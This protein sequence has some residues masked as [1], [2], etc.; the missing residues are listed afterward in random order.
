MKYFLII[1]ASLLVISC[2][3]KTESNDK[4]SPSKQKE[5]AKEQHEKV[6]K[7]VNYDGLLEVL[8][9][10]DDKLYVVNF[11]ATWCVPCVEELPHFME[12]N[13]AH[14]DNPNYQ[15]IL[16][17]LDRSNQLETGVKSF[18]EKNNIPTDCYLLD[19]VKRMDYW[20]SDIDQNW[21]GSIPIT[22]LYKNGEK[23][24]FKEGQ[25]SKAELEN[26]IT[27]HI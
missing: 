27:K 5:K 12:V 16:V 10:N 23:L 3:E 24:F 1:A 18:I 13:E 15:M 22:V 11:W 25:L 21:S 14:K 19:D 2:G 4:S 17:S 20:I 9:K 7:S 8:H 6:L 26:V